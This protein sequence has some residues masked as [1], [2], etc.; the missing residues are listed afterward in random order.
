MPRAWYRVR[1]AVWY[2]LQWR[3]LWGYTTLGELL[4]LMLIL[5]A[6]AGLGAAGMDQTNSSGEK[7][8]NSPY[9][10]PTTYPTRTGPLKPYPRRT[11]A[12]GTLK[13][14]CL[15]RRLGTSLDT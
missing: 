3:L 13:P 9:V 5:G 1:W 12:A 10:Y 15:R 8:E 6:F 11:L 4:F 2:P 14:Y 7:T